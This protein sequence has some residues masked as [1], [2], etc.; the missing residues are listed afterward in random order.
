M[1]DNHT[2]ALSIIITKKDLNKVVLKDNEKWNVAIFDTVC[3]TQQLFLV[4]S[5]IILKTYNL[6]K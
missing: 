2:N 3:D 6:L 1:F 4:D 5:L